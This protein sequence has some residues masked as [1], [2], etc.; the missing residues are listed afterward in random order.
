MSRKARLR[1]F[2]QPLGHGV[3]V[4]WYVQSDDLN[5]AFLL[6]LQTLLPRWW[7]SVSFPANRQSGRYLWYWCRGVEGLRQEVS[8][9]SEERVLKVF[10]SVSEKYGRTRVR[11]WIQWP[12]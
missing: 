5:W 8:P 6:L 7:V 12:R 9:M 4:G 2:L 10:I 11:S 1:R 3:F